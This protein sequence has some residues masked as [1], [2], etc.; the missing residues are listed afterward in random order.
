MPRKNIILSSVKQSFAL[1]W[2]NK[3][4]LALLFA[5]QIIFFVIL[6]FINLTYQTRILESAQAITDYLSKQRLDEVSVASN[7]LKQKNILGDD[8]LMISRNFNEMVKN[9]RI[10]LIYI[11]VLLIAFASL[12]WA[13]T[14]RLIH[15]AD[16]KQLT[17][18]FSRIFIVLLFYLGLIFIFFFYLFNISFAEIATV[19]GLTTKYIPFL[20]FSIILAYFMFISLSLIHKIELKRIFKKTLS[21]GIKKMHYILAVYFV[22]VLLFA[23]SIF[24]LYYFIEKNFFI[25][26]LSITLM[27]FSFVFG[28]IFMAN[29]VE[30]LDGL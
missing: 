8:P 10:Y 23:V 28:R 21:V 7:I 17:K 1:I 26:L 24:L 9:F 25:L 14:N 2:R 11:F 18:I 12:S 4:L 30:K 15:N 13:I 3:S 20:I 22:N 19:S 27:I 5:L 29:V 16:F 6:F